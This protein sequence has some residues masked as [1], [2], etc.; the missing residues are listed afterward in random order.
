M[1]LPKANVARY[2][3]REWPATIDGCKMYQWK[4]GASYIRDTKLDRA[5]QSSHQNLGPRSGF[6]SAR[7]QNRNPT[8]VI[9][10]RAKTSAYAKSA[11]P[12][13]LE[14]ILENKTVLAVN[15]LLIPISHVKAGAKSVG[16]AHSL[17]YI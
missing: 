11:S 9:E 6:R 17:K 15:N 16:F 7:D 2:I 8:A 14:T 4:K 12:R 3:I 13:S 5:S 10:M 1:C